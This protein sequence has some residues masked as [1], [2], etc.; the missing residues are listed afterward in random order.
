MH[1]VALHATNS[2][3]IY[4]NSILQ[5]IQFFLYDILILVLNQGRFSNLSDGSSYRGDQSVMRKF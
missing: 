5:I 1:E 3:L 2:D 4:V